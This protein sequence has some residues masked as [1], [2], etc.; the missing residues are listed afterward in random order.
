MKTFWRHTNGLVYVVESDS[1]G[2][3]TGASGPFDPGDLRDPSEYVCGASIVVWVKEA[4]AERRLRRIEPAIPKA[5]P[6]NSA[7]PTV[8]L[9]PR[10]GKASVPAPVAEDVPPASGRPKLRPQDVTTPPPIVDETP[11]VPRR[12]R[13]KLENG[14]TS[15]PVV[16]DPP[17][18]S[19]RP[20][21]K[22]QAGQAA[23]PAPADTPSAPPESKLKPRT[24]KAP[25][26]IVPVES[27]KP[28]PS[29]SDDRDWEKANRRKF[30]WATTYNL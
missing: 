12:A 5:V 22:P 16:Q 6:P 2:T 21:L 3:V 13:L 14:G 8:K 25:S 20:R 18:I 30:A 28:R 29:P 24:G 7:T 9:K 17:P 27:G 10:I 15:A 26:P 11:P 23:S 1:F 19:R 4:I